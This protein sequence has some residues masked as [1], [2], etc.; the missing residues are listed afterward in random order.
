M[1]PPD[2]ELPPGY[3]A[4]LAALH[5][6]VEVDDEVRT[7]HLAAALTAHPPTKA[8]HRSR[9][10]G[11]LAAA[12]AVVVIVG[13]VG[14]WSLGRPTEGDST[15]ESVAARAPSTLASGADGQRKES[16][17]GVASGEAGPHPPG[18]LPERGAT[19]LAPAETT[20]PL[21]DLGSFDEV[22]ALRAAASLGWVLSSG[23]D[24]TGSD[25]R[26]GETGARNSADEAGPTTILAPGPSEE[27]CSPP[28]GTYWT[29][30]AT[31]SGTPVLVGLGPTDAV[32]VVDRTTCALR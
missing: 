7:R 15:T 21:E 11:G 31:L 1:E 14:M 10:I 24:T 26:G 18:T 27:V 29:A 25:T 22:S 6:P 8:A 2:E 5:Q 16:D 30:T 4:V 3:A 13:V 23:S 12:A 32:V 9:R 19:E 28:A 17:V 20:P